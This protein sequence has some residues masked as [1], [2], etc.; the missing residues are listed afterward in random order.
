MD[1]RT[2]SMPYSP[3]MVEGGLS[4][5]PGLGKLGSANS[6]KMSVNAIKEADRSYASAEGRARSGAEAVIDQA[7]RELN[8]QCSATP[9]VEH[10]RMRVR[11]AVMAS[12]QIDRMARY[13]D[14]AAKHPEV[15]EMIEIARNL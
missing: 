3:P 7:R 5:D 6:A 8:N 13:L 12:P 14:L 15:A 4:A 9:L 10:A 1:D 11:D 2:S